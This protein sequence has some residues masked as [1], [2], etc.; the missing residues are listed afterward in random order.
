MRK[1]LIHIVII[2]LMLQFSQQQIIAQSQ[3]GKPL[4][5]VIVPPGGGYQLGTGKWKL[6]TKNTGG[7]IAICEFNNK[8]TTDWNWVPSHVHTREDELWYVIEGELTF[9]INSQLKSAG[10]GSL[11]FG[12]RNM[13]HSYRISKAPV[14]Y[15]LVLTPAGIDQV[16]LEADSLSKRFPRG[17][18]EWKKRLSP[19]SAKYGS[20]F[21]KDWD[22]ITNISEDK[23]M[24]QMI[25]LSKTGKKHEILSGIAGEWMFTGKNFS[26]DPNQKP[27]EFKGTATRKSIMDGR[28]FIVETKGEKF[29]MPWS[30]MK[31]I[32]YTDMSI[33]AYD[34]NK[35][36]FVSAMIENHWGTGIALLEGNYDSTAKT[37]I[38][39]SETEADPG[40]KIKTRSLLRIIS[41]DQ[42][43]VEIY[44]VDGN[45]EIKKTE[46]NYKR[47]KNNAHQ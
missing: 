7:A 18:D 46:I 24:E 39:E 28:Y 14:R 37:I 12:P 1:E 36:R 20:Y 31:E 9:N 10:P 4:D 13:V 44:Q 19:L 15:L 22:S 27:V 17:S 42:Y 32:S 47:A 41:N 23:M 38:Y 26:P 8:D 40:K 35:K 3:S 2:F 45:Q 6:T 21:E 25:E 5:Y 34:N 30:N 33:E 16:F 29:K 43:A 11:V